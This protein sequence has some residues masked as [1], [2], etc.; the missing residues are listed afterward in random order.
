MT[1][2]ELVDIAARWLRTAAGCTVVMPE[3]SVVCRTGEIPDAL[4]FRG[5]AT[6]LIECKTSRRDFLADQAKPFRRNPALG[7]GTLRYMLAPAALIRIEELPKG[8]GLIEV[9]D[10]RA[11]RVHGADPKKWG[12]TWGDFCHDLRAQDCEARILLSGLNRIRVA[13]GEPEFRRCL[14]TRLAPRATA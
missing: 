14:K 8:W 5:N 13:L 6:I 9:S 3:M 7:M 11:T 4:G 2:A 10:K 1:H 12:G